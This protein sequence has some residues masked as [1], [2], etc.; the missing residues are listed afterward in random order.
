MS[1]TSVHKSYNKEEQA[2]LTDS[3]SSSTR[4]TAVE[5]EDSQEHTVTVFELTNDIEKCLKD[6]E[7][8]LQSNDDKFQKS[9]RVVESKI[10]TLE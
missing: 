6:L 10:K 9:M 4:R 7:D 5:Q 8:S 1:T 2:P 3:S